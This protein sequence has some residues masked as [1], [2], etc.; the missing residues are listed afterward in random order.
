MFPSLTQDMRRR[1]A[2]HNPL[3]KIAVLHKAHGSPPFSAVNAD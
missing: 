1:G 2:A 3:L